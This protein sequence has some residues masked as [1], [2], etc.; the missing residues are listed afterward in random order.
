MKE[1]LHIISFDGLSKVDM[2]FLKDKPG[3]SRLLKDSSYS[4]DVE[5]VYPSL[6]YPAHTSIVTGNLPNKHGIINNT[7]FQPY[8][9]RPDWFW[10]IKDIKTKTFQEL[11]TEKGYTVASIFWPVNGKSKVKYNMP[12]IF[13]N[14][15]WS[16]QLIVSAR[17]GTPLYQIDNFKK[18]GSII[19]RIKQPNLDN[20]THKTYI[21]T[22]KN[23]KTNIT[24]VH[25]FDL[26]TIR[27]ENGFYSDEA[28]EALLRH[29]KRLSEIL[30]TIEEEGEKEDTTIVVLG[31]H[32]SKD[33]ENLIYLNTLFERHGLITRRKRQI[34]S[35]EVFGKSCG[36]S[37]YIYSRGNVG[38]YEMKNL[39]MS[40]EVGEGIEAIYDREEARKLGADPN[41]LMMLEG[42]NN[43]MFIEGYSEKP[44]TT[45]KEQNL[46][47][48]NNHGYSPFLKED[49][50]TVFIAK[51]RKIKKNKN[52]GYMRLI[53]EGPTFGKIL[54]F[55]MENTDGRVLEE[56]LED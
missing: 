16:N 56:I 23:Y 5:S 9:E 50:E 30:D 8:R 10:F 13:S 29:D 44:L 52:I 31:D 53:D 4:F 34:R 20:F 26:D 38:F 49:Y 21:N 18:Y 3:F 46:V 43:Y 45:V 11:A 15:P 19:D 55:E 36:G 17:A 25:Y 12:E 22:L 47:N 35:Y 39:L 6:T 28:Y 33:A 48:M 37:A 42:K 41:C 24:M 14:R 32:S 40:S 51:G 1:K 54:G 2:E 27:H 7:K